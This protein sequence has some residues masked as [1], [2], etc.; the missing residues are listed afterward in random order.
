MSIFEIMMLVC[1]GSAWPVSIYK[2]WI[3]RTNKGKSIF[4][5]VIV[6]L[7]YVAGILHKI[8]YYFDMVII[9]YCINFS[10]ISID[11]LVYYRNKKLDLFNSTSS[12]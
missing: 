5:L 10:M 7:G 3:S 6:L 9:L 2:S 11:L 12:H 1:F 8:F 4:F